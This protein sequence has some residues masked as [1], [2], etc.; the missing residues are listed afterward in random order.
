MNHWVVYFKPIQYWVSVILQLKQKMVEMIRLDKKAR[1]K[2][3][4]AMLSKSNLL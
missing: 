3:D 1:H 4:S 2:K